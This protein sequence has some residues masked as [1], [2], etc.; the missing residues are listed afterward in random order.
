MHSRERIEKRLFTYLHELF[1][2]S[3]GLLIESRHSVTL[4]KQS[5]ATFSLILGPTASNSSVFVHEGKTKR[6]GEICCL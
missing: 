2:P 6:I 4:F 3:A 5:G 1:D